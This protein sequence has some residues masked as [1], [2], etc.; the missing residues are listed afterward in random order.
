MT[1]TQTPS[2]TSAPAPIRTRFAPSPTGTL[3]LGNIR[4]ALFAWAFARHHNGQFVLRIEDTDLERSSES[5]ADGIL[6]D[7]T[8]LGLDI[9]EGPYYQMQRMPRYREVVAHMLADGR[10]Y[11]CYMS[12]EALDALRDAQKANGE[13]PRYDGRWR[14]ENVIKLGL[15][16]P[17]GVQPV[18]RF[19]NPDAGAVA[20]N[21]A[22]KGHIEIANSELDDLVIARPAPAG[23][24]GTPTYNFCVVV[25][26]IDMRITHVIRGDGHVMN[27]PRQINIFRAL[28]VEPPVFGHTP[29]VLGSDG[30]KLSKRHGATGLSE[31]RDHGYLPEAIINGLARLGWSHGN[32]EIF[33]P[34]QLVEWFNLESLTPSPAR[35]DAE[36]FEWLNGEHIK[37]LPVDVLA[38]RLQPF[39]EA[40]GY[41]TA[42]GP[43][44][45]AV[46]ELLRD[47]AP[48]LKKMAEMA[49]YCFVAPIMDATQLTQQIGAVTT[50]VNALL[51][52]QDGASEVSIKNR[53]LAMEQGAL[54][55][56]LLT[57]HLTDDNRPAI[58]WIK[59]Q[60]T[61]VT[62]SKPALTALL[63]EAQTRFSVKTPQVMMPLRVM[64]TGSAQAPAVDALLL[65]L[66][67]EV[68]LRRIH[69]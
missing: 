43:S 6:R 42:A 38:K 22:V 34:Q 30:E 39:L 52:E 66:G 26:D 50:S 57:Q 60:L 11:H 61:T 69:G 45:L 58:T 68:S 28:G 5:S 33:T 55:M 27:T 23:E 51:N 48:T 24:V 13:K 37:R 15:V 14:P 47:R 56:T 7:M 10:A 21:D 9:D 41:E 20:W 16:K 12:V 44:A 35:F 49:G 64:L 65:T 18:I 46:A 25:D 40:Q 36:K 1:D 31:Y 32:E 29:T 19:R 63:K 53:L 4:T 54:A 8:W 67:R 17:D 62:W 3:H 59:A 2:R